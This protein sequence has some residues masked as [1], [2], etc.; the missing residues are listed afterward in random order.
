WGAKLKFPLSFGAHEFEIREGLGR[1][2]KETV[3]TVALGIGVEFEI[4]LR[5]NWQLEPY[6]EAGF[7]K[8]LSGSEEAF[9]YRGGVKSLW[10]MPRERMER[11]LGRHRPDPRRHRDLARGRDPR[12]ADW[13]GRQPGG[14]GG[15]S[16]GRRPLQHDRAR[17]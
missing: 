13:R 10:L 16:A 8:R 1:P 12:P 15:H 14:S 5:D 17:P 11:R 9:L 3:E 7:G 6:V 2:L 4:P